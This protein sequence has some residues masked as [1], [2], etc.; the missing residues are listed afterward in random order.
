MRDD[1]GDDA[2]Q[3]DVFA[4]DERAPVIVDTWNSELTR[5]VFCIFTMTAGDRDDARAFTIRE[6]GNLGRLRKAGTDDADSD[7]A[8]RAHNESSFLRRESVSENSAIQI[9]NQK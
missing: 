1:G 3:I 6:A 2:D 5:N 9:D 4:G 7:F 8:F